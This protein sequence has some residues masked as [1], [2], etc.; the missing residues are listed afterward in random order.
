MSTINKENIVRNIRLS[1][2]VATELTDVEKHALMCKYDAL[3][4]AML[5]SNNSYKANAASYAQ[6]LNTTVFLTMMLTNAYKLIDYTNLSSILTPSNSFTPGT[7]VKDFKDLLQKMVAAIQSVGA[8]VPSNT[9]IDNIRLVLSTFDVDIVDSD[10]VDELLAEQGEAGEDSLPNMDFNIDDILG[11]NNEEAEEKEHEEEKPAEEEEPKKEEEPAEEEEDLSRKQAIEALKKTGPIKNFIAKNVSEIVKV[12]EALYK[13][14]FEGMP[15]IGIMMNPGENINERIVGVNRE[16]NTVKILHSEDAFYEISLFNELSKSIPSLANKAST[17]TKE[18][19]VPSTET[20]MNGG[21]AICPNLHLAFQTANIAFTTGMISIRKW[22]TEQVKEEGLSS[23][24]EW[25]NKYNNGKKAALTNFKKIRKWYE[26]AVENIIYN[27]FVDLNI[28][29]MSDMRKMQE[30][31]SNVSSKII[32]IAAVAEKKQGVELVVKVATLNKVDRKTLSNSITSALNIGAFNS[33]SVKST[34]SDEYIADNH[35]FSLRVIYD[36]EEAKKSV[37]FAAD[38]LDNIIAGG[39]PPSWSNVLLG[40]GTDGAYLYWK[41]FMD[42]NKAAV[43]N[44]CY[45]IYA[46]SRSGKGVMTSTLIASALCDRKQVFYTDGKPENGACLGRLAWRDGKEAYMFDGQAVGKLPFEGAL[47]NYTFGV[48]TPEEIATYLEKLPRCLFENDTYFPQDMQKKYLGLMRYLKSLMFCASVIKNRAAGVLPQDTWQIWVFDE[49]QNMCTV[50]EEIRQ[51]FKDYVVAKLGI[52]GDFSYTSTPNKMLEYADKN[53]EKYDAGIEYILN[54][55]NWNKTINV[56]VNGAI[57][58]DLG[59]ADMNIIFIFQGA[60]W[61]AEKTSSSINCTLAKVVK[62]IKS[63]KIIGYDALENGCGE[64]GQS[65]T[66]QKSW[67][68]DYVGVKDAGWWAISEKSD[69]RKSEVKVFKPYSLWTLPLENKRI[70]KDCSGMSQNEKNRYLEGYVDT[71]LGAYG[72]NAS[73]LLQ[74]SYDYASNAVKTLGFANEIKEFIYDCSNFAKVAQDNSY[75]RLVEDLAGSAEAEQSEEK[76]DGFVIDKD[77]EPQVTVNINKEEP[78]D[79]EEPQVNKEEPE[80]DDEQTV[81]FGDD[82]P[83]NN[84]DKPAEEEKELVLNKLS[85]TKMLMDPRC[86]DSTLIAYM[87]GV[88]G[89]LLQNIKV[90]EINNREENS[91]KGLK[92]FAMLISN[93]HCAA[94][95]RKATSLESYTMFLVQIANQNNMDGTSVKAKIALGML[96]DYASGSLNY[97]TMPEMSR[98]KEY[99]SSQSTPEPAEP[100]EHQNP[101]DFSAFNEDSLNLNEDN[102]ANFGEEATP[103]EK[104]SMK[105]PFFILT[106][107]GKAKMVPRESQTVIIPA[108]EEF[109]EVKEP[110]YS[111]LRKFGKKL[112]ESRNGTAYEF[113]KRWDYVL[114][115]ISEKFPQRGMVTRIAISGG[116]MAVNGKQIRL[117][118]VLGG[119]YDVRLEDIIS[120]KALLKKFKMVQNLTLDCEATQCLIMEYGPDVDGILALFNQ[121]RPLRTLGIIPAG[122]NKPVVYNRQTLMAE[123][124]KL[125]QQLEIEQTKMKMEHFAASRNPKLSQK[126]PGYT[127]KFFKGSAG[128]SGNLFKGA[129]NAIKDKNPK[130]VKAAAY[131]IAGTVIIAVGGVVGLLGLAGKGVGKLFGLFK[132]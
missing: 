81:D 111:I 95:V 35:V 74:S 118:N 32:N 100:A 42:P 53:S 30:V 76:D 89:T 116:T 131:S 93:I 15:S 130:I 52:K 68:V 54:W 57:T 108:K 14:G 79:D 73:D 104:V 70:K 107:D 67:Y 98:M 91:V 56:L 125:K 86:S 85:P 39:N 23:S 3:A 49:V 123:Q 71:L 127:A 60:D 129:G 102:S 12:L 121:N 65:D 77:D 101:F 114:D 43:S 80:D 21:E 55:L 72:V 48:R 18:K 17:N 64:Y 106:K 26:W 128:L 1:E 44:R 31:I 16:T 7:K 94:A 13:S 117:D 47:E 62:S 25:Y 113:K 87:N 34:E 19:C 97:D 75:E 51:K 92:A 8:T 11:G 50:E 119:P 84:E 40:K 61:I 20:I 24:D 66:K 4:E 37:I 69:I 9:S 78:E 63:T 124:E 38:V 96:H 83:T 27:M 115:S 90:F 122:T 46:G 33:I 112:F 2:K 10:D 82:E 22:I 103:D 6:L 29:G 5:K 28:K 45:T 36:A 59:K 105:E 132:R 120:I 110:K 126:S 99:L 109:Q 88:V 41:D 58:I